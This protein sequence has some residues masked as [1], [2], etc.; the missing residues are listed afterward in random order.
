MATSIEH[1]RKLKETIDDLKKQG[2][3]VIDLERKSPDAI[4]VKANKIY[5]VEV[6]SFRWVAKRGWHNSWT[7]KSKKKD[8][9]MFDGIIFKTFKGE[10]GSQ[11]VHVKRSRCKHRQKEKKKHLKN[12]RHLDEL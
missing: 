3:N 7:Y 2:Y 1:E 12:L 8:Y 4:A 10:L 9:N 11:K 6:L 5:A